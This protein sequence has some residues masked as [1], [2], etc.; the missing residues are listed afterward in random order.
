MQNKKYKVMIPVLI[1]E[2][3]KSK[4]NAEP[5]KHSVDIIMFASSEEEAAAKVSRLIS[6]IENHEFLVKTHQT[7]IDRNN[8]TKSVYKDGNNT[9]YM[10]Y[11]GFPGNKR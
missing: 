6:L 9:V 8:K 3:C 5:N 7:L 1:Q 4:P 2:Q 11:E 10:D